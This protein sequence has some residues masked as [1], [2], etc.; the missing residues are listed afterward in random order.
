VELF[1][2]TSK[3]IIERKKVVE[4]LLNVYHP[5]NVGKARLLINNGFD[6]KEWE[7]F[8]KSVIQHT[9]EASL[10]SELETPFGKKIILRGN[11]NTPSGKFL[12]IKSIWI[13]SGKSPILVTLY[14]T[15]N[16]K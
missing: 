16:D 13:V 4:Y 1:K 3:I 9:Q 10:V 8:A 11:L 6:P 7:E 15:K 14:P 2:D 5:D 12:M